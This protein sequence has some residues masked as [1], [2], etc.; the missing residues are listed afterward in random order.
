LYALDQ[1]GNHNSP[2]AGN[3][4]VTLFGA[5]LRGVTSYTATMTAGTTSVVGQV[6]ASG[7]QDVSYQFTINDSS[8]PPWV[9]PHILYATFSS[10]ASPSSIAPVG[11][12]ARLNIYPGAVHI[13]DLRI[14]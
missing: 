1:Y 7:S 13:T 14:Q 9:G 10:L 5:G 3:W 12:A 6:A 2:P 8:N 11:R 4:G